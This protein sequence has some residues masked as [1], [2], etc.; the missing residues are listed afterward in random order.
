[1]KSVKKLFIDTF[2]ILEIVPYDQKVL[3]PQCANLK[4]YSS[5]YRAKYELAK[6]EN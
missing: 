6:N 4:M 5:R 1:M 2:E 3:R